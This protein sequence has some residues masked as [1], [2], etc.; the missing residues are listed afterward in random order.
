MSRW[1]RGC[2]VG[3]YKIAST[4]RDQVDRWWARHPKSNV[5]M[6]TGSRSGV[7]LLDMD[8]EEAWR[9]VTRSGF[10]SSAPRMPGT[11]GRHEDGTSR[12]HL[13]FKCNGPLASRSNVA[14][15][16]GLELLANGKYVLLAP[17]IHPSGGTYEW[18]GPSIIN[19]DLPE[20]PDW[21]LTDVSA[22]RRLKSGL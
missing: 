5:A 22:P 7:C 21:V 11:S 6:P 19:R 18:D 9:E 12:G 2:N 1:D 4:D 14:G 15:I 16:K 8:S 3:G 10:D 20:L 17:S 13:F